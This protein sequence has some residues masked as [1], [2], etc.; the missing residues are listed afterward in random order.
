[1]S[2][3]PYPPPGGNEAG[4]DRPG[5]RGWTPGDSD[6]PTQQFGPSGQ[7]EP[8][9]Q[10]GQ[11]G[12]PGQYGPPGQPPSGSRTTVIALVVAAVVVLAAVGVALW[13]LLG[14]G[15]AEITSARPTTA[16]STEG[17]APPTTESPRGSGS[18]PPPT[19]SPDGLGADPVFDQ[20]AQDCYDGA[21]DACDDLFLESAKDSLYEAYGDTCA[22]RQPLGGDVFCTVSFPGE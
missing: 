21:M 17:A 8:T 2:Q 15:D 22:G 11:P 4:G 13:L 18:L 16:T 7:R 20:Y 10:F 14:R 12:Q 5:S 3:P 19:L 9:Q 1:M 6:E